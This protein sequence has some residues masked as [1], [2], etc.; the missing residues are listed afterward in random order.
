[1][2]Q[3][4]AGNFLSKLWVTMLVVNTK[5]TFKWNPSDQLFYT[6]MLVP[7]DV[8]TNTSILKFK[9]LEKSIHTE[10]HTCTL[11]F[12]HLETS[13]QIQQ[14]FEFWTSSDK[15]THRH[16]KL[17]LGMFFFLHHT[18]HALSSKT[19]SLKWYPQ[20]Y[21]QWMSAIT[22]GLH[23]SFIICSYQA[24]HLLSENGGCGRAIQASCC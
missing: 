24:V 4:I 14:A 6:Q 11:E 2:H 18:M 20:K 8:R 23:L 9:L 22:I 21:I 15:Y 13:T 3:P 1:M 17:N 12:G 16:Q 5:I 19:K 10:R 7:R